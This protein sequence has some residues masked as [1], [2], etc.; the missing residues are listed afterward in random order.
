MENSTKEILS[1]VTVD[2]RETG[3]SSVWMEKEG[4]LR[5]LQFFLNEH[6]LVKRS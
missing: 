4:F 6:I 3:K 5:T 1:V 2:K